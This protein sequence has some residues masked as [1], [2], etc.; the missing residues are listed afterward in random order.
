MGVQ[1]KAVLL[2]AA[3]VIAAAGAGAALRPLGALLPATRSMVET[4]RELVAE[5]R[6]LQGS[7][8]E[9]REG[10]QQIVRQDELLAEQELLTRD[11]L[12]QLERQQQ[13]NGESRDLLAEL[14]KAERQTAALTQA[15][16]AAGAGTIASVRANAAALDQLV[17]ATI[18][19]EQGSHVMDDQLDTLLSEMAGSAENF[20]AVAKVKSAA[21]Q[22]AERTATWWERLRE[23][24]SW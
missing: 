6:L 22:A 16:D 4:T 9:V 10:M 19:I 11:L 8:G 18:R 23:W 3:G 20:G 21:T 17:A 13:L 5:T 15:A 7:V 12:G 1:T 14:L 2:V 24:F